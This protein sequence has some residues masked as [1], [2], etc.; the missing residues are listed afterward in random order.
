[1]LLDMLGKE[2][3]LLLVQNSLGVLEIYNTVYPVQ[4]LVR[5]HMIA[6]RVCQAGVALLCL[7]NLG[8]MDAHALDHVLCSFV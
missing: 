5:G 8:Q 7:A 4:G 2:I 3:V 1:M 6:S